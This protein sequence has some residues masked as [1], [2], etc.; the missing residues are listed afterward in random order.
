[1][2]QPA[3]A[4]LSNPTSTDTGLP[5]ADTSLPP[6]ETAPAADN[7]NST[8]ATESSKENL[9]TAPVIPETYQQFNLADGA[10]ANDQFST[11]VSDYAKANGLTQVQAQAHFDYST[12]MQDSFTK[13]SNDAR[14]ALSAKNLEAAKADPEIGGEHWNKTLAR[15]AVVMNRPE[16]EGAKKA[17]E[18]LGG[19]NHPDI[20][21]LIA[22][23][24]KLADEDTL[25]KGPKGTPEKSQ[26]ELMYPELSKR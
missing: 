19:A 9:P 10:T 1:M 8:Q 14:L 11:N 12:A 5:S 23:Y 6:V 25:E 4:V 26:A 7:S 22:G 13:Q 16:N 21:R 20:I 2:N 3:E 24:G 15:V 18:E 17:F